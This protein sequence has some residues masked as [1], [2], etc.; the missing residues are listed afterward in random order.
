MST[1]YDSTNYHKHTNQ[2]PLQRWLIQRFHHTASELLAEV[3]AQRYL[4]VGCGEGFAMREILAPQAD[5]KIVGMDLILPA[6]F[7]ARQANPNTRFAV[8][9]LLALPFAD[10]SFEVTVCLE[11]LEHQVTPAQGLAELRR[12]TQ[13]YL[14]LSVPNEPLFRGANFLRG[15][16][17]S[18]WGNDIGHLQNWSTRAFL[19]FV[20]QHC[21]VVTWRTSF[22]WTLVLCR[23]D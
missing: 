6:V 3:Q 17:I 22:P 1:H 18:R 8:G 20:A 21:T 12:V 19:R 5:A 23:P 4:D 2:N 10:K 15:K 14:L 11:V 7:L 13:Q 9:D 16:N